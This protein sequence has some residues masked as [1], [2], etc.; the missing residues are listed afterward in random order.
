MPYSFDAVNIN[1]SILEPG[2][3]VGVVFSHLLR[4]REM[5]TN[6][7]HGSREGAVKNRTQTE[8]PKTDSH[9][10]RNRDA[11]SPHNGEFMD[12]KQGGKFKGVAEE[13]DK[14]RKGGS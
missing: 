6:T 13:P 12:N 5:A 8:N 9:V 7:G 10:K 2:S 4:S 11:D 14:R 3:S 1:M